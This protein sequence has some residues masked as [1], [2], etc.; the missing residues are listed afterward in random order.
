MWCG[1]INLTL[2]PS[3]NGMY[4]EFLFCFSDEFI[5][6]FETWIVFK[7]KFYSIARSAKQ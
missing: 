5:V 2:V 7:D 6:V 4:Q 3:M 1:D